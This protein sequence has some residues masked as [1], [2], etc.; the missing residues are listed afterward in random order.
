MYVSYYCSLSF[1]TSVLFVREAL[2]MNII[3]FCW[4]QF[5][6]ENIFWQLLGTYN[7]RLIWTSTVT[8]QL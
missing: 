7:Y 8:N 6:A 5:I 2:E 4:F 1:M 3:T